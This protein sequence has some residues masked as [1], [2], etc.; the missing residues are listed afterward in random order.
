M[1][2]ITL[3]IKPASSLCNLQCQYCFY[4][5]V[6]DHR[7]EKSM[8]IMT[9]DTA[10][11]L[12]SEAFRLIS[13]SGTIN[14][15]FQ[16]GEPTLAGPEFFQ[17]FI[18]FEQE[19]SEKYRKKIQVQHALQTNGLLLDDSWAA[20]LQ[21]HHFLIGLSLDGTKLLHDRFRMDKSG[22]GTWNRAIRALRLLEQ[23]QIE[24][25]LLCVVT[26]SAARHPQQL[27]Q[28]LTSLGTHP[29]QLIPCMEPL[30]KSS[31]PLPFSLT[32]QAYGNFLCSLF[33]CW[34]ADFKH[35]KLVSIRTFD[36]YIRIL[37][38][39]P[40]SACAASGGCGQALV[41]E[42]N[43]ALYP[44]DFFVLDEW[45]LG[46][47]NQHS[48]DTAF[49]CDTAQRFLAE[50]AKR[51][52]ECRDCRYAPLCRG[53]CRRDFTLHGSN[54]YCEAFR[55]FF[56]YAIERLEEIAYCLSQIT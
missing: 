25:N 14:F 49:S 4:E 26:G 8:G 30:E 11:H 42:G 55:M 39:L 54:R 6:S 31:R 52:A 53:G 38:R 32:P 7:T 15:L 24:T 1:E 37:L 18:T 22:T 56:P 17:H 27:Y 34:Y 33:D 47:I 40:P 45:Y 12:I 21:E 19:F 44:C 35:G 9:K 36:D 48:L 43:G 50:G 10:R 5:D 41:V 3:L 46:N 51:P 13:N 29:L 2:H 28:S 20:F 23:Y 16:G